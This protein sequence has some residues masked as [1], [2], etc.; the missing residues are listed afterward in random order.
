LSVPAGAGGADEDAQ[1]GA[2][3]TGVAPGYGEPLGPADETWRAA[4]AELSPDK[5]LA[6]VGAN[7]RASVTAVTLVGTLIAGLGLLSPAALPA[8]GPVRVVA[9][10]AVAT[11]ALAV[12]LGLLYLALRLERVNLEILEE[13]QL[14]YEHQFHR[15]GLA[16][17]ASWLLVLAV[18][19]AAATAALVVL[20][21]TPPQPAMSLRVA[22]T[23]DKRTVEAEVTASD[24]DPGADVLVRVTALAGACPQVVL[25]ESRNRA[26]QTGKLAVRTSFSPLPCNATFRLDVQGAGIQPSSVTVP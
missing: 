24:V 23:G 16:A 17:A 12:L 6:R 13:V 19:L 14:W 7:A 21:V 22:G 25:L 20:H 11:A 5:S 15:A 9:L 26:D 8:T 1:A 10:A 4:K 18:L 3:T 2:A